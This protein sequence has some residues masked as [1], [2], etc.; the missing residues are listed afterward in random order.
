MTNHL[1]ANKL[2]SEKQHGFVKKKACVTNLLESADFL[3]SSM[4]RRRWIDILFLDFEKAF[5]KVPHRRLL[6]KLEAYGITGSL[7]KWFEGF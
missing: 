5:D 7:L 3:T 4:A 2:I 1:V 6:Q